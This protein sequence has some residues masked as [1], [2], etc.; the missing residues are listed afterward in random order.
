M[1]FYRN[2]QNFPQKLFCTLCL[3]KTKRLPTN[4][5]YIKT[6]FKSLGF[7]YF[8]VPYIE[9]LF[10]QF[11]KPLCSVFPDLCIFPWVGSGDFKRTQ[12]GEPVCS[13]HWAPTIKSLLCDAS[14]LWYWKFRVLLIITS[15]DLLTNILI[16]TNQSEN[17]V[18]FC[19]ASQTNAPLICAG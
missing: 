16:Y 12:V 8:C 4:S 3:K 19:A 15:L 18:L 6:S 17:Y 10:T 14:R 1:G 7:G 2:Y 5:P 9:N 11:W 13:F